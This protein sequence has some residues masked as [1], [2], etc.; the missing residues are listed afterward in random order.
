MFSAGSAADQEIKFAGAYFCRLMNVLE[1]SAAA[2][3][4]L[5]LSVSV[6]ERAK[7]NERACA[8]LHAPKN[9]KYFGQEQHANKWK[10]RARR[11][12]ERW[13]VDR[14]VLI[15]SLRSVGDCVGPWCAAFSLSCATLGPELG[16][17]RAPD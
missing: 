2:F 9:I 4:L 8:F 7:F 5:H 11:V 13:A 3:R 1:R 6:C 12:G 10:C 16:Y 15:K 17:V 14:Q